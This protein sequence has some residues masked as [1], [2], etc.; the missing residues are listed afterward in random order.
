MNSKQKKFSFCFS[1][2]IAGLL[3][4]SCSKPS[5]SSAMTTLGYYTGSQES[6]QSFV[7]FSPYLDIVS[8][9]V[10]GL[11][12]DGNVVG[13]DEY[14]LAAKNPRK[15]VEFY[16]CISNWNSD[17]A[18]NDF[19]PELAK[20]GIVTQKEVMIQQLVD[21][22]N[23]KGY[24][25][26]NIDFESI[27]F[28]DDLVESRTAFNTFIHDLAA[29]LHEH[30]KKLII[31]VAAKESDDPNNDWSY[32]YDLE[33]LGKDADYL[34]L[35][36]YDEHGSWG[37]PGPVSSVDWLEEV[38]RYTSS[39]V[40]PSKLLI[41]LPAYGYDWDL[42]DP[43]SD[44]G[45]YTT[46]SFSWVD[47]PT[48]I[49]KP[50]AQTHWDEASQSPSVTYTENGHDHAAWYETVESIQ[51]KVKLIPKYKLAGLS[52]WALGMEDDHF[53]QAA[54]AANQ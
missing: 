20:I 3:L 42:S 40:D 7:D 51:S 46:T 37:D 47:V 29:R 32:P 43:G 54:T 41:G 36:T 8:V 12:F 24:S 53:W 4:T 15:G 48:L 6:Y 21:L 27:A 33:T 9:D 13:A 5:P 11:D 39:V 2:L 44:E 50:G 35:M 28:S 10:Y 38:I 18:V 17:E 49:A 14:E 1:L 31:S 52:V 16:A 23:S 30:G 26:I 45:T 22:A 34:Q 19:D 25:G